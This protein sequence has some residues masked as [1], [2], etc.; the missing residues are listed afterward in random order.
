M[1]VY[2]CAC[3]FLP[4][5]GGALMVVSMR[6]LYRPCGMLMIRSLSLQRYEN[7]LLS[8]NALSLIVGEWP[9]L[10]LVGT[11]RWTKIDVTLVHCL[12]YGR[13]YN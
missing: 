9:H 3:F 4:A 7:S 13:G 1:L 5:V 11:M 10:C 8:C 2:I 6:Y 12:F